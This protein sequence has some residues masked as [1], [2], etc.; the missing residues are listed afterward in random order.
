MLR[1]G[2]RVLVEGWETASTRGGGDEG[3]VENVG[4]VDCDEPHRYEVFAAIDVE[5]PN[6]ARFPGSTQR[7]SVAFSPCRDD[8][9]EYVGET[10]ANSLLDIHTFFP[11]RDSWE[12]AGDREVVSTLFDLEDLYME[13]SMKESGR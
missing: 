13:G 12:D 11:S 9:D 4:L 3:E 8:F 1:R 6:D 7:E 2:K 10:Y 5:A